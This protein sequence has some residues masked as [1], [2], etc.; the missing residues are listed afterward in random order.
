MIS[1]NNIKQIIYNLLCSLSYMHILNVMH[2][3]IK[4]A[5]ILLNEDYEAKIC[6]L[7]LS[8]CMPNG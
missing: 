4:S 7:G 5:N 6:D 2:R 8:R 1:E 3:D